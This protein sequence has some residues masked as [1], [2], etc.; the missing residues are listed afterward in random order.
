MLSFIQFLQFLNE[1]TMNARASSYVGQR[2]VRNYITPYLPGGSSH[3]EDT[4]IL[5]KDHEGIPKGTKLT[6]KR[7]GVEND[8]THVFA[9]PSG[10]KKEI[11][12]PISK[13]RKPPSSRQGKHN[14]EHA[15]KHLWNHFS[16]RKGARDGKVPS[17]ED[18][19]KEIEKAKNDK[20][21]P[22]HIRNRED[23]EFTGKISGNNKK[24]GTAESR[25]RA[26]ETYYQNSRDAAHTIHALA[27]HK[28]YKKEWRDGHTLE[29]SGKIRP[30][31]S[32]HYKSK[33]VTGAGATS[34]GDALIIRPPS[35]TKSK[36]GTSKGVKAISFKKTGGSQLMSSGPAEFHAIYHH[37]LKQI[38]GGASQNNLEELKNAVGHMEAGRHKEASEIVDRLHKKHPT[39]IH[40]VA[41]EALS[42]NG[43]FLEQGRAT[44]VAAIGKN[45]TVSS[46]EEFMR[47]NHETISKMKIRIGADKHGDPN[48]STARLDLR[49]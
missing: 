45:A 35:G 13:I 48:R 11:K 30:E 28:D 18:M 38:K 37:A 27:N 26:N 16:S 4:H 24:V 15:V 12:I 20:T 1:A 22:L 23:S 8:Q 44:H 25:R 6:L 14:E 21:H 2:H 29:H 32:D 9:K 19:H 43:K 7:V 47:D 41:R 3:G 40:H 49:K 5:E 39:L 42:G 36:K 46:V 17:V 33:G 31:L 10:S 34:K